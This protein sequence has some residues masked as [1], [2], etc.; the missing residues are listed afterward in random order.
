G[1]ITS[2]SATPMVIFFHALKLPKR[3][4]L[5]LLNLLLAVTS[6][7]Q[8]FSYAALGL[9]TA[10]VL[11]SAGLT[12]ACVAVGVG[13]GFVVHDRVNQRVFNRAV[14]VVIFLVGLNLVLRA[15]SV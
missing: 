7:V 8:V 6:L 9:Y 10:D 3:D 14:I 2:V 5:V 1:G 11:E 12:I 15:L 4:F 13:L